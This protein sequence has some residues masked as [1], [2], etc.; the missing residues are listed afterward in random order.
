MVGGA[1]QQLS[2]GWSKNNPRKHRVIN[3]NVSRLECQPF[4]NFEEDI[5][6]GRPEP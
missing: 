2:T 4:I 3:S 5:M 6:A 1:A